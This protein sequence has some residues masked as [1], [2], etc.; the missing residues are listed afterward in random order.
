MEKKGGGGEHAHLAP[1]SFGCMRH[2]WSE[3]DIHSRKTMDGLLD[4]V[5]VEWWRRAGAAQG[6]RDRR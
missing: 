1:K 4:G 6:T 5:K 2:S 3:L